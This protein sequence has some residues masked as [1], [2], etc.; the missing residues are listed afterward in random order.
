MEP[1]D[2]CNEVVQNPPKQ[3]DSLVDRL[4]YN[5]MNRPDEACRDVAKAAES[6]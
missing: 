3:S 2:R 5:L 6:L 1:L 4:I